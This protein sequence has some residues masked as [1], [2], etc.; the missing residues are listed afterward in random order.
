MPIAPTKEQAMASIAADK[1]AREQAAAAEL[2]EFL[3]RHGVRIEFRQ[4]WTN[5]V[6]GATQ[7]VFVAE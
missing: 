1:L 5:G 4:L 3:K 7:M 2:P 6:P